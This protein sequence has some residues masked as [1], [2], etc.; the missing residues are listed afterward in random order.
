MRVREKGKEQGR[1]GRG[2]CPGETKDCLCTERRQ[3]WNRGKWWFIK[4]KGETLS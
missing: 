1:E 3:T 2:L 4:A